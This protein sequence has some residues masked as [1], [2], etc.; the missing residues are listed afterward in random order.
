MN[1]DTQ[2]DRQLIRAL[3]AAPQVQ[4]ADDFALR[5][6]ARLP[7][8]R[9]ASFTQLPSVGRRVA[10]ATL[11]LLL[12]AMLAA[13]LYSGPANPLVR[14]AVNWTCAAEFIVLS[15]W[16]ALRPQALR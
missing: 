5:L 10:Y 2:F 8:R 15:V 16:L 3:E 4:V 11:A 1:S 6:M 7:A 13:A 9:P 12:A 14:T